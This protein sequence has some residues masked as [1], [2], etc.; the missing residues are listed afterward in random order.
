ML[1]PEQMLRECEIK[2]DERSFSG[3]QLRQISSQMNFFE[4]SKGSMPIDLLPGVWSGRQLQTLNYVD[5]LYLLKESEVTSRN[6][7]LDD[8]PS[9]PQKASTQTKT[10]ENLSEST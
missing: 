5:H 10:H 8:M 6:Y 1:V 3:T 2:T 9:K 7:Q 4:S